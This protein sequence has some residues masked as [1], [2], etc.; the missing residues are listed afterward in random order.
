MDAPAAPVGFE[1]GER[2]V[3]AVQ[4][5]LSL[6][7][8]EVWLDQRAW[9]ASAHLNIGG[10]AF[11]SG[12]FDL[13][14]FKAALAYLVAETQALRLVP[15][16]DGSQTL[17]SHV[18]PHLEMVDLSAA[19]HPEQA[20][21]D[22]WLQRIQMPF[23]LGSR[24]SGSA[25][26][27]RFALL[28]ASDALHG[29]T[30][31]FHH[32]VMDGWGTSLI[33][34]R[35]SEI[36]NALA[37]HTVPA[38]A[39]A[40]GYLAFIEESNH[41]RHA[42]AF[43]HDATYWHAHLP[44]LPE[45]LLAQRYAQQQ[46]T[47]QPGSLPRSHLVM[48]RI[49]RSDYD[50]LVRYAVH[51]NTTPFNLFLAALALY[52][53]RVNDRR[54]VVVGVPSLNRSGR[55]YKETPGMF[56]G[57]MAIQIQLPPSMTA[58]GLLA[59]VG[60]AMRGALRHP[61]YPLSE[62]GRQ[63][64]V[65]RAGRDGVFDV[66]L[67]FERQDYQV[68]FGQANLVNSR[69]LFSGTARYPL[70]LTVCEFH[71]HEDV[72]LVLEASE[73]CFT[74]D[75][76]QYLGHRIWELVKT[77]M[78]APTNLVQDLPLL[79]AQEQ[80]AVM[81]GLHGSVV[82][83]DKTELF[84][85]LFERH[86]A[87][88]PQ[89]VAL[90]WDGGHMSY[91]TLNEQAALLAR[92]LMRLGV[93]ANTIVAFAIARSPCMVV[94]VLAIAKA[95]AAF[96]PLD[97]DAPV[98]RLADILAEAQAVALLIQEHSG[99]RLAHLHKQ[100]LMADWVVTPVEAEEHALMPSPAPS[101]LAY[102][103]FTSGSTGRPKGVMIEHATLSRRLAWLS[104]VYAVHE[105]DRS[106]LATQITFDPSLIE[107]CLP[108]IHG[109][110]VALPPPGR[111]LPESL[112]DFA[113]AHGVTIMAFVPSTLSRFLEA[114]TQ[115][116]GLKLRVACC[117]GE[118]LS[119][120]LASR[121]VA[122]TGA[123][124]YNVYGPTEAAIFAT[125]WE[126][127]V[128]L[129]STAPLIALPVG[130]PV[131]DT[132]IYV[133]DAELRS[134][135]FGVNGEICIGGNALAR[136]YLNRPDL[137][138]TAFIDDPHQPGAKMYRTGDRGWLATDGQLH[139]TGRVDRQIKLR[140]YRI[141]LGEI[142][143]T[144]L[145]VEGITQAAAKL[146]EQQDKFP[147]KT[148]IHAWVATHHIDHGDRSGHSADSLQ[149]VLRLRLPDYM[150]PAGISVLNALPESSAGKID[151]QALPD[152][153][154][155]TVSATIARAP[156]GALEHA[157]LALWQEV[158][159]RPSLTIEDNFFDMGGDSLAAVGILT[160]I[161]KLVGRKVPMYLMTERPTVAGLAAALGEDNASAGL[162]ISL[163]HASGINTRAH[164]SEDPVP[165]LPLPPLF[166]LYLAASGHGDLMRFQTLASALDDTCTLH[167]LQPPSASTVTN[168]ADLATLYADCVVAQNA[169]PGTGQGR[170]QSASPCYLAGFSVGGLAA[171]ETAR[172]LQQRGMDVRGLILIDTIYPSRLWGGTLFWRLLGRLVRT[173]RIQ[174]LSMNGRRL[175]VM[176]KDPGLV[177]QVMAVSG[178]RAIRFNGPTLL[179]KSAGLARWDRLLFSG[180]R[181]LM[182]ARLAEHTVAG[183]HGSM[184]DPSHVTQLAQSMAEMVKSPPES[185]YG[186]D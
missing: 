71:A 133:L 16:M 92:R 41:Y 42:P 12:H 120:E 49:P 25:P 91:A 186:P 117:G 121:F 23:V 136:G 118:V 150:I 103:L 60:L 70:S 165:L 46:T 125:A 175:G 119:P 35:W 73:A 157:L 146:V 173:L 163:S 126:C 26:P 51:T 84:I 47:R 130:Q 63:L 96:L 182:G 127:A 54:D 140:G 28:R 29:L 108:L 15:H 168:I 95:G 86:A 97:P 162:L 34:Q 27:W 75:E 112:V 14:R 24:V 32:L 77:L 30:I 43:E 129:H 115:R 178:Y 39:T 56:V 170:H 104:R 110:S 76:A 135:P 122:Q 138:Q 40:P 106:A 13:T 36:Y 52:F 64:E 102:V 139:F 183:L 128:N 111:V 85:T 82:I 67:S 153:L 69:Q 141:E 61:R 38:A 57:A 156:L 45:R 116:K 99:E 10:G 21:R 176:L 124:L 1:Q 72:E 79:P 134:Q 154:Q 17:L 174:D 78:A 7:Q 131:D 137:T 149:R 160:G 143:A 100:T 89:A 144:L 158:L 5:D 93:T 74:A 44:A 123:R 20:I 90:V 37:V 152:P 18:E 172:Q 184:F 48:Q 105:H 66:L 68:A 132:R 22:W 11:L 166:P 83:H 8:R 33:M 113:V 167:M 62:L 98:A 179:I 180:W 65:I 87:Q 171:L 50:A 19:A 107:L 58:T 151:Y 81:Q 147:A 55:R 2:Q 80:A 94:A 155:A 101:D 109:A 177:G 145:A 164:V 169:E 59:A 6:S 161:E 114:A 3:Q 148:Q 142:E 185:H 9:P 53:A 4:L 31:Q 159:Q 88:H 181:R